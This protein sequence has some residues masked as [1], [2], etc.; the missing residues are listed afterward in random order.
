M[1]VP[2]LA[3]ELRPHML[4]GN[5]AHVSQLLSLRALEPVLPDKRSPRAAKKEPAQTTKQKKPSSEQRVE[6]W[7]PG[8]VRWG[9]GEMLAKGCKLPVVSQ[10]KDLMCSMT[11]TVNNTVQCCVIHLKVPKRVKSP[12]HKD[13]ML[14]M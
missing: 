2:S 9:N 1:Q 12:H 3:R 10:S 13:E 5:E 8:T 11:V 6:W 14:I 4:L 7:L